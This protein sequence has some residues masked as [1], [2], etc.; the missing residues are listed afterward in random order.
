M[1]WT[2]VANRPSTLD[3]RNKLTVFRSLNASPGSG[4]LTIDFAA[5]GQ[6]R[7]AWSISEFGGM[8]TSG[9]NGADA[10]VQSASND[11][12]GSIT[13][14]TVTLGAFASTDNATYGAFSA[15]TNAA[16]SPGAGFSELGEADGASFGSIETEWK[17]SNDT[18]VDT[19]FGASDHVCGIAIEIAASVSAGNFFLVL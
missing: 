3:N 15:S 6:F 9:T 13:S 12:S 4:A 14:L 10:V 7:S 17:N 2:A 19:T 11:G 5:Q 1:T 16:I 18:S 8:K